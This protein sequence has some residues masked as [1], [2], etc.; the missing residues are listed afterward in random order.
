MIFFL[1]RND[2]LKNPEYNY[3][4]LMPELFFGDPDNNLAVMLNLNPGFGDTN[5]NFIGKKVVTKRLSKGY[6]SFAKSFPYLSDP[7]FILMLFVGGIVVKD[8]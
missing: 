7:L 3:L 1:A 2:K 8:G 5:K 4:D 6:S